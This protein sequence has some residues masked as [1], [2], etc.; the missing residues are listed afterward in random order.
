[1]ASI[2][3][4]TLEDYRRFEKSSTFGEVLGHLKPALES[5]G[6]I[7]HV[8]FVSD[9]TGAFSKPITEIAF[10]TLKPGVSKEKMFETLKVLCNM[11]KGVSTYGPL[12]EKEDVIVFI[13]GWDSVEVSFT[14]VV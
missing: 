13:C 8:Q 14:R 9:Y 2:D 5:H 1:M 3:W 6:T 4:T 11:K 10:A 12:L 7:T